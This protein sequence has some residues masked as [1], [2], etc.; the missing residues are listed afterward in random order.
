M[1]SAMQNAQRNAQEAGL[2]AL[3]GGRWLFA[4]V[5]HG[6]GCSKGCLWQRQAAVAQRQRLTRLP[7]L[8]SPAHF[9]RISVLSV[10]MPAAAGMPSTR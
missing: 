4:R 2:P 7:S 10:V 9:L 3:C 8:Q 6:V 1:L 5:T